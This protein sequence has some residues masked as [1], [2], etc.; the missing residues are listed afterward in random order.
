M[1]VCPSLGC[2]LKLIK[3]NMKKHLD[4]ECQ[5]VLILCKWCT[6][7]FLKK[8]ITEH[9]KTCEFRLEECEKCHE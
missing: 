5:F 1:T 4:E 7:H 3:A 2:G 8:D 6:V 9:T